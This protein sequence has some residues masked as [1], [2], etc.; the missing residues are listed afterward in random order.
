[1]YTAV[2]LMGEVRHQSCEF[3]IAA[4]PILLHYAN[5]SRAFT[6]LSISFSGPSYI[7]LLKSSR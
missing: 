3:P 6:A 1:L 7:E 5:V 2:T 4:P